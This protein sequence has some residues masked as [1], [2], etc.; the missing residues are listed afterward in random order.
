MVNL[1][2]KTPCA[3]LLPLRVG[4][5]V[6]S[7]VALGRMWSLAPFDGRMEATA[8]VVKKL[9]L[10]LPDTG[11]M[12]QNG[13]AQIIWFGHGQWM[14]SGVADLP[15]MPAAVTDQS[16][17]WACVRVDGR[18]R[19]ILARLAPVDLRGCEGRVFRTLVGHMTAVLIGRADGVIDVMVMRSMAFTLVHE[20]TVAAKG[21]AARG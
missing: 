5:T 6:L 8:A 16:D 1:I 14:V 17:G 15:K 18:S 13:D 12:A 2:E 3:G 4:T 11:G 21:V 20:L 9:G 19:D 7:E 10:L